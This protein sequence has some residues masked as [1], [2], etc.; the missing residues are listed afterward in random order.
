LARRGARL[1][2][3]VAA[4]GLDRTDLIDRYLD[5]NGS[6]RPGGP[7][8]DLPWLPYCKDNPTT[9]VHQALV[10]AAMNRR[11]AAVSRMLEKGVDPAVTDHRNFTALHW[12]AYY[13]YLDTVQVLLPWK[14]P[15]EAEN[16]FGG[17][18]LDQTIW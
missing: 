18:V 10:W 13:R 12:A 17:T 8:V 2:T 1:D 5:D 15:L 9:N 14:P 6:L 4:T 16:E 3:I 7:L 11:N